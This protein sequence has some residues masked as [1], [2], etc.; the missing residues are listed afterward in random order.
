M[1]NN[2][3]PWDREP[4]IL[5][6]PARDPDDYKREIMSIGQDMASLV[7]TLRGKYRDLETLHQEIESDFDG[8][9]SC[10]QDDRDML[11]HEVEYIHRD[12]QNALEMMTYDDYDLP[13]L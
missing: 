10:W 2:T 9:D 11:Y 8:V 12:T 3:P 7:D 5:E 4:R 6:R 13:A 1:S